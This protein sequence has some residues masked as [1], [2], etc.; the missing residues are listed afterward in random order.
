MCIK[1]FAGVSTLKDVKDSEIIF[2]FAISEEAHT[3]SL[4]KPGIKKIISVIFGNLVTRK[5]A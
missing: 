1:V 5:P 2:S 4:Y 3:G